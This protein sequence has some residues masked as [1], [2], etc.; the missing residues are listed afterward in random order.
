MPLEYL[1]QE[2]CPYYK[3]LR[4]RLRHQLAKCMRTVR[5]MESTS[6]IT[7]LHIKAD[8]Y[9]WVC[10]MYKVSCFLLLI[11]FVMFRS[12]P[13]E[14]LHVSCLGVS[15]YFLQIFM[16]LFTDIQKT[17]ILAQIR[18][19]SMSGFTTRMYGNVCYHYQS[20]VGRDYKAWS[21]WQYL[22]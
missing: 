16:P 9:L 20:F 2:N 15:K 18:A 4:Y 8:I 10:F 21:K 13:L 22:F 7:M 6:I 12:T 14:A 3:W 1:A 5:S 17:E 19:F 11:F